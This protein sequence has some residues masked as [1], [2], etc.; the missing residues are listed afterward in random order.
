MT[1][2]PK[3]SPLVADTR[4]VGGAGGVVLVRPQGTM[5]R[6]EAGS[7]RPGPVPPGRASRA[8]ASSN[9]RCQVSAS[10]AS[11]L[12]GGRGSSRSR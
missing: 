12:A 3:E 7:S 8:T 1:M 4:T 11:S 9:S 5:A 2:A 6:I 10:A